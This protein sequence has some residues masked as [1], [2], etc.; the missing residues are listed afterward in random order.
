MYE[1]IHGTLASKR[2]VNRHHV[3]FESNRYTDS[4]GRAYR[5]LSGLVLPMLVEVHN[6]LHANVLP[7]IKPCKLLMVDIIQTS[8]R[9]PDMP[10]YDRFKALSERFEHL[11]HV[12]NHVNINYQSGRILD[13]L[14]QQDEYISKGI[15][16]PVIELEL[17]S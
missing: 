11:S 6:D 12:S 4:F 2:A 9:L 10:L 7:P 8:N 15:V 3:M 1:T 17:V 5:N 13:N 14:R 16:V